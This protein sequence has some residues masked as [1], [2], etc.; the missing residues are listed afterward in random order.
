MTAARSA[1]IGNFSVVG[2]WADAT[3]DAAVDSTSRWRQVHQALVDLIAAGKI[4]PTWP[5]RRWTRP[6]RH[7]TT[8]NSGARPKHRRPDR[9]SHWRW[10]GPPPKHLPHDP[11]HIV[12]TS[13]DRP[14]S[15]APRPLI[16]SP[17]GSGTR[18]HAWRSGSSAR[19]A[20][21]PIHSTAPPDLSF[22]SSRS[23]WR[24]HG[25]TRARRW[26]PAR[27]RSGPLARR[28]GRT[29]RC[30]TRRQRAPPPLLLHRRRRQH[31][32]VSE[33]GARSG[34]AHRTRA[35]TELGRPQ[36][37]DRLAVADLRRCAVRRQDRASRWL[38]PPTRPELMA[39]GSAPHGDRGVW[40]ARPR[41][42]DLTRTDPVRRLPAGPGSTTTGGTR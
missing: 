16:P 42:G 37:A 21:T 32:Q 7:S 35:C 30:G 34:S 40:L 5:S 10:G 18:P 17:T 13:I 27:R 9:L 12:S 22:G 4:R 2:C 24:P 11:A 1:C 39:R 29:E 38:T 23:T 26:L 14:A 25:P 33:A 15:V 41:R 3:R 28:A 8:T 36:L 19:P 6:A 20:P 31:V